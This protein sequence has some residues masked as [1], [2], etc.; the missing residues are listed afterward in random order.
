MRWLRS[1]KF[2]ER[3]FGIH[4]LFFG[5]RRN[6]RQRRIGDQGEEAVLRFEALNERHRHLGSYSEAIADFS[7]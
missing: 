4:P 7:G 1:G 3:I 6:A 2:F 5:R